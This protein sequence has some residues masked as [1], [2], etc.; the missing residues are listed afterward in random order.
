M[1]SFIGTREIRW[2]WWTL[3]KTTNRRPL[4]STSINKYIR[5][6]VKRPPRLDQ[7]SYFLQPQTAGYIARAGSIRG[8]Y[9][10]LVLEITIKNSRYQALIQR[11]FWL[12]NKKKKKYNN[13]K[14]SGDSLD[15]LPSF[16]RLKS[17]SIKYS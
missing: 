15:I 14:F 6:P 5:V 16:Y 4:S 11:L 7:V 8:S 2:F 9:F 10:I 3:T 13:L 1:W 12:W 17:L